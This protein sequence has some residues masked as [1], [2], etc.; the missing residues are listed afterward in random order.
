MSSKISKMRTF[1]VRHKF[2]SSILILSILGG[3]YFWYKQVSSDEAEVSYVTAEIERGAIITTVSGSGQ[4]IAADQVDVK[5][6]VAGDV[7]SVVVRNGQEVVAGG[8][9]VRLD[10]TD[11]QQALRDRQTDLETAELELEELLSPPDELDILQ[12]ENLAASAK[13]TLAKEETD[14]EQIERDAAQSLTNAYEDAYSN[15]SDAFLKMP[16][17]MKNLKD[18]LG[19]AASEEAHIGGYK[20][21]LGQNSIFI[22]KLLDNYYAA[23][24][25][26]NSTFEYFRTVERDADR[27]TIYDLLLKTLE[28]AKDVSQSLEAARNMYDAIVVTNYKQWSVAFVVD[29]MRPRIQT[30]ISTINSIIRS[31][32]STR[33]I[34]DDV[35]QNTPIDIRD[36][37]AAID[38]A[39]ETLTE[40]DL[41]LEKL[42]NGPDELDIRAKEIA[43]QQKKDA[44]LTAQEVLAD[45]TVRAPFD[46]VVAEVFVRRGDALSS[47]NAVVTLITTQQFA[48]ISLNEV[49]ASKIEAGQKTT[50]TFDAIDDLSIAGE[51]VEVDILGAV[52]QGVVTYNVLVAFTGEVQKIKP[53]MSVSASIITA[54]KQNVLLVPN[55]A[56]KYQG[57]GQ[58]V[59]VL[60]SQQTIPQSQEIEVGL[61]NDFMSEVVSGLP[62]GASVV[63]QTIS[64]GGN[65]SSGSQSSRSILP[66]GR[67]GGGN[68][69]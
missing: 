8:V 34:I 45:H 19:T 48:E 39:K 57:E 21:I 49:D 20:A 42:I 26:Y 56:I 4:V 37:Q 35:T 47:L 51:V 31:L 41:S 12:A 36:A 7:V 53:G 43:V 1:A 14:Y 32:Q 44:L 40:R 55:S 15:I 16:D 69:R 60:S 52:S 6:K 38:A 13:R 22:Q 59:D 50:L 18:V 9:L 58:F 28:T 54:V 10:T 65:V 66:T 23:Q 25:V 27:E 46:G 30:D 24:S 2:I 17:H 67:F 68:R 63:T 29:L 64:N 5:S 11:A 62:E 3:G 33:D 61:S